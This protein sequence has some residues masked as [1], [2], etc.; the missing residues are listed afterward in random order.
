MR[1]FITAVVLASSLVAAGAAGAG[2]WATAGLGPP[3]DGISAGDK[4]DAQVT[5][6]QHGRT[7]LSGV[8]P[9][10]TIRNQ[11]TGETK[12]FPAKPTGKTGVYEA[13]VVFPEAGRWTYEVYDGFTQYGGA[14]THKFGAVSVGAGSG[15]SSFELPAWWPGLLATA[16]A[17]AAL[18]FLA[19][20]RRPK[21]P[22]PAR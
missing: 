22:V 6:L 18:L 8:K 21:A 9:T 7:P 11:K 17:A 1:R 20:R 5:I 15:G 19:Y 16:F 4:W 3:D 2:G 13:E 12:T 10:V 14:K